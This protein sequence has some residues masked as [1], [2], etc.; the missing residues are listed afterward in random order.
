MI[1]RRSR[2]NL[3]N[4][5][6]TRV[7]ILIMKFLIGDFCLDDDFVVRS[8]FEFPAVLEDFVE[9]RGGVAVLENPDGSTD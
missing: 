6:G 8:C 3:A 9:L 7:K 2:S 4:C 1:C 5:P